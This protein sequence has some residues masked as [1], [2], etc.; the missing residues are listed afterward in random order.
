MQVIINPRAGKGRGKELS[1]IIQK[2]LKSLGW[3]GEIALTTRPQ[4]ACQ[5]A[6]RALERGCHLILA[7][8]GDGTINALLPALVHKPAALA[9]LPLGTANDL[10]RQWQIPMNIKQALELLGRGQRKL[11]DII[12]TK[13]GKFIAGCGGLGFDVAIIE[14]ALSWRRRWRGLFPFL[15]AIL[16]E[17]FYYSL[18]L[19]SVKTENWHYMGPGWQVIFSKIRQYA[20]CI[21]I[22]TQVQG[23]DGLM[24]IS[25][26]P[27]LPKY[28]VL[29]RI[30]LLPLLGLQ[31]MPQGV[32][33][34]ASEVTIK[35]HPPCKY[36]GDGELIG[37]TPETFCVLPKALQIISPPE[38]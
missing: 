1:P 22:P 2:K 21:K 13:S 10:A 5:L 14:R 35:S 12:G 32:H 11:V 4:D 30:F 16:V 27:A 26:I 23:D 29:R 18:P 3:K 33:L 36:H 28:Q 31:S 7:C 38:E 17:I 24:A 8:G 25:F 6:M 20:R 37:S 15:A 34:T 9:I 19:I